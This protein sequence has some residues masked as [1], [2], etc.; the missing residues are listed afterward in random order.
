[1]GLSYIYY[2]RPLSNPLYLDDTIIYP[3]YFTKYVG[4]ILTNDLI[5]NTRINLAQHSTYIKNLSST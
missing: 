4:V 2:S 3:Q 5:M 1:M